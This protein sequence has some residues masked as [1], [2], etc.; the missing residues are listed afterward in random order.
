MQIVGRH[1]GKS[2]DEGGREKRE[3]SEASGRQYEN[4]GRNGV[5]NRKLVMLPDPPAARLILSSFSSNLHPAA[6]KRG[7]TAGR[8]SRNNVLRY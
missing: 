8:F 4:V 5:D 1:V 3:C 2:S 7:D 6:S